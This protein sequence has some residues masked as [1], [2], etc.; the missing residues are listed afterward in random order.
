MGESL[1]NKTVEKYLS[2]RLLKIK[3]DKVIYLVFCLFFGGLELT[4]NYTT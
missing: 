1:L 2:R 4:E 3:L